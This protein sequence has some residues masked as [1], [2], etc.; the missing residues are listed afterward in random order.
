VQ[1]KQD[2]FWVRQRFPGI[3]CRAISA[4]FMAD[5]VV[6]MFELTVENDQ[7]KGCR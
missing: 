4:Q 5:S 6:A 2:I 7:I 3:R 1:T